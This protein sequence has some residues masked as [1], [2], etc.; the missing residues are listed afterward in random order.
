[1][2]SRLQVDCRSLFFFF[3]SWVLWSLGCKLTANLSSYFSAFKKK[4]FK[5]CQGRRV[6]WPCLTPCHMHFHQGYIIWGKRQWSWFAEALQSDVW[7]SQA[8][9]E[10]CIIAGKSPSSWPR[11][12]KAR[13]VELQELKARNEEESLYFQRRRFVCIH[14]FEAEARMAGFRSHRGGE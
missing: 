1:V 9:S 3:S 6:S 2:E 12:S 5:S 14:C 4:T 7:H 8:S 11:E 13:V 10:A